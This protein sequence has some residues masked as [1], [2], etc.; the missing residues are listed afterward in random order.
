MAFKAIN[1]TI[2]LDRLILTLLVYNALSWI[3]EY[4]TLSPFITQRS[5]AL[6]KVMTEI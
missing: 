5:I 6:K 1:N 3:V 2:R 4:D